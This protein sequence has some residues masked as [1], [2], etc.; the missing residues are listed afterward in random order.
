M[1]PRTS[2]IST[3]LPKIPLVEIGNGGPLAL[4]ESNPQRATKLIQLSHEQYG[5]RVIT[6][7]DWFSRAWSRHTNNTHTAEIAH[8]ANKLPP[9]VWFMNLC[10]EWGCTSGIMKDPIRPGMQMLRTLDWPFHG[11][12]ENLVIAQQTGQAGTFFNLTWSGFTGVVQAVAPGRFA[13]ALNQAPLVKYFSLPHWIGWIYNKSKMTSG[14]RILPTQLLRQVFD[15]C[16]NYDDAREL[17][18]VTPI[19]LP[20]I[21]SLVGTENDEGCII[22]RL[23]FD[24]EIHKAPRAAANHWISKNIKA[25]KPRG[26]DSFGRQKLMQNLDPNNIA[27]FNWLTYPLLNP[28]TRLAM[29]TNPKYKSLLVQGF[30]ENGPATEIFCLTERSE[31]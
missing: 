6:L 19:A 27:S 17:L 10:L 2:E 22:E 15:V 8:I 25:G 26:I 4:F 21:F 9:G 30:E 20:V 24:S 12:G 23:E 3:T 1:T 18:S 28:D 5:E 13:I 14:R 31:C 16:Q 11:L 7:L 29:S